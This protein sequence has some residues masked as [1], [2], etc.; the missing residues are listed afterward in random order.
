MQSEPGHHNLL[1]QQP[2]GRKRGLRQVSSEQ[3]CI[4]L[5]EKSQCNLLREFVKRFYIK[6]SGGLC[7]T[8]MIS[9]L[10]HGMNRWEEN[11]NVSICKSWNF[12]F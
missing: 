1:L 9:E 7:E 10:G 3:S 5:D 2:L 8:R 12:L 4:Q 11:T 6:E